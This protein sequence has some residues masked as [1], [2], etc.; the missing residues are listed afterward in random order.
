[1]ISDQKKIMVYEYLA[2]NFLNVLYS[3]PQRKLEEG[4]VRRVIK[5]VFKGLATMQEKNM[6]HTGGLRNRTS[7]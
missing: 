3:R 6:A 2:D 7:L 1:M 4:E 5:V